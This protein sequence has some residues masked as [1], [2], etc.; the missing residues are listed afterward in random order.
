MKIASHHR[1]DE[2]D[3][4]RREV[5]LPEPK[6]CPHCGALGMHFC[7]RGERGGVAYVGVYA[8]RRTPRF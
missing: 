3:A 5:E 6:P 2:T 1:F 7:T 8:K 4:V